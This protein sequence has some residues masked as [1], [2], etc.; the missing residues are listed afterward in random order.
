MGF[1]TSSSCCSK[2][3][4][5]R[6]VREMNKKGIYTPDQINQACDTQWLIINPEE[7]TIVNMEQCRK[8]CEK[9]VNHLGAIGNGRKFS[10]KVF[11]K[12]YKKYDTWGTQKILKPMIYN[13]VKDILSFETQ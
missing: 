13:M 1:C 6:K 2:L 4:V 9:S 11:L 3:T 8:I 5:S 7:N 10:K 12:F